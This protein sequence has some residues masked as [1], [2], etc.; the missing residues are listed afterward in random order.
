VT[1]PAKYEYV[2]R[3]PPGLRTLVDVY[4]QDRNLSF[5]RAI[6]ELLETHPEIKRVYRALTDIISGSCAG[7]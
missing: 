7:H 4:A 5:N 1:A 6:T 2:M 3:I